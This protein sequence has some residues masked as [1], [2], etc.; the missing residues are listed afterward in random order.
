MVFPIHSLSVLGLVFCLFDENS[1]NCTS[2]LVLLCFFYLKQGL[3][4]GA[5]HSV[6]NQSRVSSHSLPK[7]S[8]P[9]LGPR[10]ASSSGGS[11]K[12]T[13]PS[14]GA[15]GGDEGQLEGG[16]KRGSRNSRGS[17]DSQASSWDAKLEGDQSVFNYIR[18]C[19]V[20][21]I[22]NFG[23]FLF[24]R[25]FNEIRIYSPPPLTLPPSITLDEQG[26][27]S[28]KILQDSCK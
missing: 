18:K 22:M 2:G 13:V 1:L 7:C 25:N 6:D 11:C 4:I 5:E 9:K 27:L 21:N 24:V 28:Y 14:G 8:S 20:R 19:W 26:W 23:S 12:I 16:Q 3:N 10:S 17:G 15:G